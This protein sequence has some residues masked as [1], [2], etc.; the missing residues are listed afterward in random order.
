MG[1][2]SSRRTVLAAVLAAAALCGQ[3]ADRRPAYEAASIKVNTGGGTRGS[4]GSRSQVV[5]TNQSLRRLV[6]RAYNVRP[7]QVVAPAWLDDVR[8][9]ISAKYPAEMDREERFAML[10]TLLEDRLKLAAHRETRDMR[11]YALV[12][13]KGGLKLKPVANTDSN[14]DHEGRDGINTVKATPA[15]MAKLAEF[16]E[17]Q[18]GETVVNR[19]GLDGAYEFELRWARGEAAGSGDPD[20]NAA[21]M[22]AIQ[23]ALDPVGLRLQPA[24]VRVEVVVVDHV[25][26]VPTGN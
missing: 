2:K 17:G 18:I 25:E 16:L 9:D 4:D 8:F 7:F 13:A 19:T 21:M 22:V 3:S 15:T 26:R 1:M 11:G 10:R 6:E 5:F 24:K 12:V 14:I 23:G 20:P